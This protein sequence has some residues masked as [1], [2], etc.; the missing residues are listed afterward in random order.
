M[1]DPFTL[2]TG[3]VSI[4]SLAVQLATVANEF[5]R[6]TKEALSGPQQLLEELKALS[7]VLEQLYDF[8]KTQAPGL[9]FSKISALHIASNG[10]EAR[11]KRISQ[12]LQQ[13][14]KAATDGKA[15]GNISHA[16][17]RMKWPLEVKE[18]QE[19]AKDIHHYA[20]VF[21]LALTVEG[22]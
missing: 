1:A 5:A 22:W 16:L 2:A 13:Y 20:Q 10:Y 11:L 9:N 8:L 14:S 18:T 15:L 7:T 4:I 12:K 19:A 3:V 21:M 6:Y 17:H